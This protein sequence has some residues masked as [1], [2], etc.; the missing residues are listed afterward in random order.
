MEQ[1]DRYQLFVSYSHADGNQVRRVAEQLKALG[2]NCYMD[3]WNK[4]VGRPSLEMLQDAMK[5]SK[6]VAVFVA[7]HG[8]GPWHKAEANQALAQSIDDGTPAFIVWMPGAVEQ[9]EGLPPWLKTSTH[10]DLRNQIVDGRVSRRGLADLVSA[11]FGMEAANALEWVRGHVGPRLRAAIVAIEN[12][13]QENDYERLPVAA[14]DRVGMV[15]M[16]ETSELPWEV[17]T[18]EPRTKSELIE[19][20]RDLFASAESDDTLL[21]YFSGHGDVFDNKAVLCLASA[22]RDVYRRNETTLPIAELRDYV[23]NSPSRRKIV[24]LDC[25]FSGTASKESM[26]WG[27]GVA[28]IMNPQGWVPVSR[29]MSGLTQRLITAWREPVTTTG[30]LRDA[31]QMKADVR[32]NSDY[33]RSIPLPGSG[34][35]VSRPPASRNTARLVFDKTGVLS[36]SVANDAT[37]PER[38]PSLSKGRSAL[39]DCTIELLDAVVSLVPA[40]RIPRPA[41]E[42]ALVALGDHLLAETLPEP[43]RDSF[44]DLSNWDALHLQLSFDP[45]WEHSAE[46]ESVPWECLS[47]CE[48]EWPITIERV[49]KARPGKSTQEPRSVGNVVA[50]NVFVDAIPSE[51][52][53]RH[54][55]TSLLASTLNSL[56]PTPTLVPNEAVTWDDLFETLIS[57]KLI[58]SDG[59]MMPISDIDTVVLFAPVTMERYEPLIWFRDGL[60]KFS[61]TDAQTFIEAMSYWTCSL[62]ILETVAGL[63]SDLAADPGSIRSLQATTKLAAMLGRKMGT[64]VIAICHGPRFVGLLNGSEGGVRQ[65]FAGAL[66]KELADETDTLLEA[67]TS[68]RMAVAGRLKVGKS[69]DVGMPIVCRAES[70]KIQPEGSHPHSPTAGEPRQ[71]PEGR[72][73][74]EREPAAPE[75]TEAGLEP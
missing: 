36:V 53:A 59:T 67:A 10:A 18:S 2:I 43:V 9:P 56:N 23:K 42:S 30:E 14:E 35:G 50:W 29:P 34:G 40:D 27:E 37:T 32:W 21:F 31:L 44:P 74:N 68:A 65:T 1:Q 20:C 39:I 41:V 72:P 15:E 58:L 25:C 24:V 26:D 11:A 16:L 55:F 3:E 5:K 70:A 22:D 69:L 7:E 52:G 6:A 73:R 8:M 63:P 13:E 33:S 12:Y 71:N 4:I 48:K 62:V 66:L 17:T 49:V 45:G 46:W 47:R 38:L 19:V 64:T 28:V 60:G 75:V 51:G 57:K 61:P 54:L